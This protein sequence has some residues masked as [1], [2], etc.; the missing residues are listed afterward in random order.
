ML[1]DVGGG[2]SDWSAYDLRA[3]GDAVFRCKRVSEPIGKCKPSPGA[4]FD[5]YAF[6]YASNP[7]R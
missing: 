5:I 4:Q 7:R 2:T 1:G 3:V 6:A